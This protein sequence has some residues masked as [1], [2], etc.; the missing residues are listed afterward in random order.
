MTNV[1]SLIVNLTSIQGTLIYK[2]KE[3]ECF[4]NNY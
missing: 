3:K 4:I 1:K 2:K